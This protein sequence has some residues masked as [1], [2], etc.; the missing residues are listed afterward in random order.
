MVNWWSKHKDIQG[1]LTFFRYLTILC[2]LWS[3]RMRLP[4]QW[5]CPLRTMIIN[6]TWLTKWVDKICY[7]KVCSG[8]ADD[9]QLFKIQAYYWFWDCFRFWEIEK[10]P[11]QFGHLRHPVWSNGCPSLYDN[12]ETTFLCAIAVSVRSY[13]FYPVTRSIIILFLWY[14]K[15]VGSSRSL[16]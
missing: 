13:M 15:Q 3:Q 1:T 5:N 16:S 14:C 6:W 4:D 9:N 11:T 12:Q 2:Q 7:I 8:D 10:Q